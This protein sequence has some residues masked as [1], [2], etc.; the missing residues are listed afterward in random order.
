MK[1]LK[2]SLSLLLAM[3]MLLSC[4]GFSSYAA[5]ECQHDFSG[6]YVVIISPTCT[7]TG[8]KAKQCT[9]CGE[10][11]MKNQ[12]AIPMTDHA[13]ILSKRVAPTCSSAG[14]EIFMCK[15]CAK[16]KRNELAPLAHTLGEYTLLKSPTCTQEGQEEA[17]CSV[18][19]AHK[20]RNIPKTAH[21]DVVIRRVP[22]TC[23]EHGYT[24]G[25]ICRDCHQ[26]LIVPQ[27]VKE[28][29]HNMVMDTEEEFYTPSTCTKSGKAHLFCQ[30]T[31]EVY[32]EETK[33]FETVKCTEVEFVKLPLAPHEDKDGDGLCDECLVDIKAETCGCFCHHDTLFSRLV[34]LLNTFLSK[35][36]KGK[37]FKCCD[38][39]VP[40]ELGA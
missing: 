7:S 23:T 8:S 40:Y 25:L 38:D 13:Y 22:A 27:Y 14:Y 16:E 18:C 11:D 17:I 9:L 21:N 35:L 34:R 37:E 30:N 19:G 20:V 6:E 36:I 33:E 29:G 24:E 31:H 2:K 4:A 39:M 12:V 10:L 26:Y 15:D 5:Q 32:N 28:T 3:V 1:N